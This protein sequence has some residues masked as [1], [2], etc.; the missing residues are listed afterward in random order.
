VVSEVEGPFSSKTFIPIYQ[1]VVRQILE[2]THRNITTVKTW[3][4]KISHSMHFT[5]PETTRFEQFHVHTAPCVLNIPL[6]L[7]N[8][9]KRTQLYLRPERQTIVGMATENSSLLLSSKSHS[10]VTGFL[11][12]PFR[13]VSFNNL[14]TNCLSNEFKEH[15]IVYFNTHTIQ[16]NLLQS[17]VI[18]LPPCSW[19]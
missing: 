2:W 10:D 7:A 15:C 17:V 8:K 1:S 12:I 16:Q 9:I 18:S 19:L 11:K 6:S 5:F 4:L 3:N 14:R 13:M